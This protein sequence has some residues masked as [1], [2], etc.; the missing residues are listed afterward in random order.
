MLRRESGKG[1]GQV[2]IARLWQCERFSRCTCS[3]RL[4]PGGT[5]SSVTYDSQLTKWGIP[6]NEQNPMVEQVVPVDVNVY[7][8]QSSWQ[9]RPR[10]QTL[11]ASKLNQD[12]VH[13]DS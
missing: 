10:W 7:H 1:R 12:K 8:N 9:V 5:A 4:K 13:Y 3:Q 2:G 6:Q 11:T